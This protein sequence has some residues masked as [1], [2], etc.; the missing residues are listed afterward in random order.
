MDPGTDIFGEVS[1]VVHQVWGVIRL[2]PL[3]D[4]IDIGLMTFIVYQVYIW[5]RG[6][7][8]M[9]VVAGIAVL[10]LSYLV[11]QAAGLFLTSWVLGGVWAAALI[12]VI[13]IFQGEIR[14][15]LERV[16]PRLPMA[17]LLRWAS[18]VRLPEESLVTVAEIVFTMASKRC[19]ALLV[20]EREDF[21]EPLMRSPG[22]LIDANVSPELLETI[23]DTRTLLH[24]GAVYLRGG[25]AYRAG[26][27]LPLSENPRLASY[28]GTRHR[29]AL[30]ISEQ[31][32]ALAVVVSEERGKVS[33][34]EHGTIKVVDTP[35]ELVTWLTERL[36]AR[37]DKPR[38]IRSVKML[39]THNWRPKLIALASVSL[40][41]YVLVG[42]QNAEI[43]FNVPVVYDNVPKE[44]TVD[45]KQDQEVY[46]R[47]RGSRER[48]NL[49][50]S[51]RLR[52]TVDLKRA[53]M[54]QHRYTISSDDINI[55]PGLQ[56]EDVNP[57]RLVLRLIKK[58]ESNE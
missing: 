4:L 43:G 21:I 28:Y 15:V 45:G 48:L 54:G 31:S 46:I 39:A 56:L 27:V 8:A 14:H 3:R 40:L 42:Q 23:F 36:A 35:A 18:R 10:G 19:G 16:N 41:W 17:T 44:L 26:A 32:D 51:S 7:R 6:T 1:A 25:R 34:V 58:P 38:P 5:F 49:L 22:T 20:F 33:V 30:G 47:V 2:F 13:V 52:V 9:R 55:P 24:D 29:A 50:D 12:F 57:S 37:E 53:E 11:A